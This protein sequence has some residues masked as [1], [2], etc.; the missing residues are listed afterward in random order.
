MQLAGQT[1]WI[2]ITNQIFRR[3]VFGINSRRL[4]DNDIALITSDNLRLRELLEIL[5]IE[6]QLLMP[7]QKP[8][9]STTEIL[10]HLI[11]HIR[12]TE[13]GFIY[14]ILIHMIRI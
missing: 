4:L 6:A 3:L 5:H 9:L 1:H 8:F 10:I 7:I 13:D 2:L 12:A 11:C 14:I